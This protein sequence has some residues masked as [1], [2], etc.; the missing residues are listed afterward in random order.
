[1]KRLLTG[2]LISLALAGGMAY[3]DDYTFNTHSLIGIEGGYNSFD[4][5][6][7][8]VGST[9]NETKEYGHVGLKIGG[10]TDNYRLFLSARSYEISGFDHAN[11]VGAEL[12]YMANFSESANLFI[13]FNAGVMNFKYEVDPTLSSVTD[14]KEY[15]GG[16]LGVNLHLMEEVDFEIGARYMYLGYDKKFSTGNGV[17]KLD[18]IV[19]GYASL[20]Y[21]FKMD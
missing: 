9:K 13:G 15:Y 7:G 19:G 8:I 10:Q 20:I 18:H 12:Q 11:S 21:K 2:G 14:K 16:D 5:E 3:A 1:M 4:M 17:A 6:H